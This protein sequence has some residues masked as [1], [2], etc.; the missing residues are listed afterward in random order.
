MSADL[1]Q[2]DMQRNHGV[3]IAQPPNRG[4]L[5]MRVLTTQPAARPYTRRAARANPRAQSPWPRAC[6]GPARS[7]PA[8]GDDARGVCVVVRR[9]DRD[10]LAAV[11]VDAFE[12]HRGDL[13]PAGVIFSN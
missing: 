13:G 1:G 3:A 7:A 10:H 4:T 12:H 11:A 6:R 5:N 2:A 8:R 9:G